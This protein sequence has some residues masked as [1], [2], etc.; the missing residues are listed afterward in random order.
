LQN[1]TFASEKDTKGSLD[2]KIISINRD[3]IYKIT[4]KVPT[5]EKAIFT[6]MR[7]T[8]LTPETIKNLKYKDLEQTKL[9]P[10]KIEVRQFRGECRRPPIF[11]G[12]EAN[13]YLNQ[14]LA[15]RENLTPESPLFCNR[16]GKEI[17]TKN[18]SRAFRQTLNDIERENK[19]Y[20]KLEATKPMPK[21]CREDF[22]LYSLIRFYQE[23]AECYEKALKH[24][25][26]ENDEFYRSLYKE[27][28]MPF[29]EIESLITLRLPKKQYHN[30][31]ANQ[32]FQIE[33]M[34]QTIARDS[35][36]IS[37]ILSLIYN[38]KGDPETGEAEEIGDNFIE[39]WKQTERAQS[40]NLLD[41]WDGSAPFVPYKDIVD[42]LAKTLKRIKKPYDELLQQSA[43]NETESQ[44]AR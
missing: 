22:S 12:E 8:G 42:E 2:L 18:L 31:V 1:D 9:I 10:R 11:I 39:L 41:C 37:S 34:K 27:K 26:N 35:E 30:L 23:N 24:N 13:I 14:Y 38:N 28:A 3:L 6:I 25:P 36:Y 43:N 40:K 7:Q 17:N 4:K 20:G 15:I 44:R 19:A 21:L 29:L 32:G 5:R 16:K 33:E